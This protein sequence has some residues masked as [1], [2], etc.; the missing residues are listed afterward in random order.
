MATEPLTLAK[1]TK[2]LIGSCLLIAGIVALFYFY[3]QFYGTKPVTP[4]QEIADVVLTHPTLISTD[5]IGRIT[6]QFSATMLW[7]YKENNR[8]TFTKPVAYYYPEKKPA[9]EM[10]ADN[11]EALNGDAMVNLWDH[12]W[13]HQ[14]ADNTTKSMTLTTSKMTIYPQRKFAENNVALQITQPGL[15]VN[16]VGFTADFKSN[17][18]KLLSQTKAYYA[19]AEQ[20]TGNEK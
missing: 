9:W 19:A 3:Q 10:I 16:A 8:S 4:T 17:Q 6:A 15:I 13:L 5:K 18:V 11:G 2:I 1:I 12:V 20:N 14:N 7:H